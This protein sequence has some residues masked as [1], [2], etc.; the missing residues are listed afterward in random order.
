MEKYEKALAEHPFFEGLDPGLIKMI[1]P[2]ASQVRH[3][4]EQMIYREGDDANQFLLIRHGRVSIEM[5]AGGRGSLTIQT[6]GPGE[7]LGWSWLFP[8]YRRRFDARALELTRAIALDGKSLREK[9]AADYR[10]GYEL[11]ARFSRVVVERLQ[12]ASL[13]L[14]DM[15][16]KRA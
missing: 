8:P 1:A 9:A 12:A 5:H 16:G 15:Y 6:V 7:V 10:L 3:D 11:F 14:L 13:Q 2:F 4:A